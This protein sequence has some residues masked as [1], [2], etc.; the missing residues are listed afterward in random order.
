VL[1]RKPEAN[2]A[3]YPTSG[4]TACYAEFGMTG[5]ND[6]AGWQTCMLPANVGRCEFMMGDGEGGS[7]EGVGDA[8]STMECVNMV[9]TQKPEANGATYSNN[10]GQGC[11]AE[12]GMTGANGSD[13]WQTCLF[14]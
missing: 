3:T 6:S 2:G 9:M 4:G 7:E 1:S 5:N 13:G 8:A 14:V 12:F 10:G 11:Y